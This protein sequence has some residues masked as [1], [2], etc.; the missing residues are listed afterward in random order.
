VNPAT[1]LDAMRCAICGR[2]KHPI[3]QC[4]CT[5]PAV[6]S[7]GIITEDTTTYWALHC[8]H[9]NVV[10]RIPTLLQPRAIA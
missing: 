4:S 9:G 3:T 1:A 10:L 7:A 8:V 2:A 6:K 5:I